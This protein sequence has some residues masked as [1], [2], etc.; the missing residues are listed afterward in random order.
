MTLVVRLII[1]PQRYFS[2]LINTQTT[3][4]CTLKLV[5]QNINVKIIC[6]IPLNGMVMHGC[7][8][9]LTQASVG[10]NSYQA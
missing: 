2:I 3:L 5:F 4:N 9:C 6:T 8:L 1:Y 10:Y 7:A